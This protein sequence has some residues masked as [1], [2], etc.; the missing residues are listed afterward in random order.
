MRIG[1]FHDD[2]GKTL[3]DNIDLLRTATAAGVTDFWM[4]DRLHW[5]P[6]TLI[7]V[8]G[9]EFPAARFG[10]AVVRTYPRHPITLA[11]QALATQAAIGDRLTLGIGPSHAPIIESQYGYSFDKPLRHVR[12]YLEAL[13]P[14]VRQE[15]VD[16][17]GE[18]THA[19]AQLAVPG[20]RPLPVLISALGP[21]MLH[22]AGEVADGTLLAWA[23][24]RSIGEYF[25]PTIT[26][27]AAGRP[28]PRV[29]A[30]VCVTVTSNPDGARTWLNDNF[31]L[32]AG[33]PSYRAVLDREGVESVGDTAVAGDETVV[34]K[35]LERLF[36][37]GAT[38]VVAIAAGTPEEQTR[39]IEFL[40]SLTS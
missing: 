22:L 30:S 24:P 19:T 37:A 15:S 36:D 6:L 3:D 34:R 14:L 26:R 39:T 5:D 8:L 11:S 7:T 16:Y 33:L 9:R 38:D 35:E 27:A 4:S 18:T 32:A 31:G 25:A 40:G 23:G 13:I 21:K 2:A 17:H 12:E 20:T 1:L 29:A 28:A 10:T